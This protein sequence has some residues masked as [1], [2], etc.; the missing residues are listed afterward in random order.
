[1][2]ELLKFE[3]IN[4]SY[5]KKQVLYD[6][7]F[8]MGEGEILGIVGN[9][10]CGKS[11]LLK[12]ILGLSGPKVLSGKILFE[13]KDLLS[14]STNEMI[15]IRGCRIS[16]VFQESGIHTNPLKTIGDTVFESMKAHKKISKDDALNT[17]LNIFEN[18][19]LPDP[20]EF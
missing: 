20:K 10:G 13:N 12:S 18:L 8:S 7:S 4:I 6:L 15:S 11:T 14:L 1:M 16:M 9:S 17:A 19:S 5:D 2:K 3:D